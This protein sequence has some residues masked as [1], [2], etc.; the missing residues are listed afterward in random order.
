MS[1]EPPLSAL[2]HFIF[3][4]LPAQKKP[5]RTHLRVV[6]VSPGAASTSR[7]ARNKTV[8]ALTRDMLYCVQIHRGDIIQ[9]QY[10]HER[11]LF[12][13]NHML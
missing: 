11:L 7:P 8:G 2:K 9:E 1:L 3:I 6:L 4:N 12:N 5:G 10:Y 13:K